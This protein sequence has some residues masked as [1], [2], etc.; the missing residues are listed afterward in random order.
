M[1]LTALHLFR[2]GRDTADIANILRI[3]EAEALKQVSSQRSAQLGLDDPYTGIPSWP[4]GRVP[5]AGKQLHSPTGW[6]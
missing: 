1:A 6:R 4:K 3:S 2:A 5:Y